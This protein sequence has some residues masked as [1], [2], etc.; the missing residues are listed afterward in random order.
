VRNNILSA[1]LRIYEAIYSTH[2]QLQSCDGVLRF[3]FPVAIRFAVCS[4][5][6]RSHREHSL[7]ISHHS[8]NFIDR[9]LFKKMYSSVSGIIFGCVLPL[10]L[11]SSYT[12]IKTSSRD[13]APQDGLIY[14][15][16]YINVYID[17]R[18]IEYIYLSHVQLSHLFLPIT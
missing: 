14:V 12:L 6:R 15:C 11:V 7:P 18:N 3:V 5:Y 9:L 17:V 2:H 10:G 13:L 8:R 4:D 1:V 16:S